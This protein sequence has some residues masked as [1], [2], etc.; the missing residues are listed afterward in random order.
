MHTGIPDFRSPGGFYDTLKKQ[1]MDTPEDTMNINM[2]RE[3]PG[4]FN[5]V[6]KGIFPGQFIPTA[7]HF[8]LRLLHEQ[9]LLHR[10]FTQNIDTMERLVGI[11][12]EKVVEAH[13]TFADAHCIECGCQQRLPWYRA[14]IDA[15]E[16]PRCNATLDVHP[17]AEPPAEAILATLREEIVFLKIE[18][19]KYMLSNFDKCI[20][21]TS[22]MSLKVVRPSQAFFQSGTSGTF[23]PLAECQVPLGFCR[24]TPI[25]DSAV[26]QYRLLK[27][28]YRWHVS[29]KKGC[30]SAFRVV[31]PLPLRVLMRLCNLNGFNWFV[32]ACFGSQVLI[33]GRRRS[34]PSC[35]YHPISLPL[36]SPPPPHPPPPLPVDAP[37]HPLQD[38]LAAGETA[39][40]EHPA[41]LAAWKAAPKTRTC[42]G[43]VKAARC[44]ASC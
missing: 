2:F 24:S 11:P 9:G 17:P 29:W 18:K 7:T 28:Q 1:G 34:T 41:A 40:T 15:G 43:L 19:G 32:S 31:S 27:H 8:F 36:P 38:E 13:G 16:I 5:S 35:A 4:L 37:T 30:R 10:L 42:N 23:V 22:M 44:M 33:L 39:R 12:R 3:K 6:A 26:T 25:G 14:L 20:K 21:L